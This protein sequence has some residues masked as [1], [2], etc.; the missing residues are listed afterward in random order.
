MHVLTMYRAFWLLSIFV[1]NNI[2]SS[3]HGWNSNVEENGKKKD[4]SLGAWKYLP[5]LL[6]RRSGLAA[7]IDGGDRSEEIRSIIVGRRKEHREPIR[8]G[9]RFLVFV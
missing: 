3:C 7:A 8:L 1:L 5:P 4:E 9:K 6:Y 2:P